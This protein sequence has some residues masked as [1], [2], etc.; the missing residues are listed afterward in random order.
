MD[1][2]ATIVLNGSNK[3]T[4]VVRNSRYVI[5]IIV[6]ACFA[7]NLTVVFNNAEPVPDIP[8]V[9]WNRTYT[10]YEPKDFFVIW[11][12]VHIAVYSIIPFAIILFENAFLMCL[13]RKHSNRMSNMNNMSMISYPR[14]TFNE[15][16]PNVV[17]EDNKNTNGTLIYK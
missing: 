16:I 2:M 13:A 8:N 1:R 4:K 7:L 11:D 17:N 10:C 14:D 12:I 9:V 6:M 3:L 5:A 15:K